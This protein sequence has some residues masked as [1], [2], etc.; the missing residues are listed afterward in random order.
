V[1]EAALL[2]AVERIVGG[3]E[4]EDDLLRRRWMSLQEQGDE[5][6]FDCPRVMA[7]P[8]VAVGHRGGGMLQS[9]QRA[10]AGQRRA[11]PAPRLELADQGRQH[12]IMAQ[13]VMVDQVLPRGGRSPPEDRLRPAQ[14]RRCAA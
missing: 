8:M 5:Q 12:R 13:L 2:A 11:I 7:D 1:E 14:C 6:A 10:L 4:V 3:I 9:V